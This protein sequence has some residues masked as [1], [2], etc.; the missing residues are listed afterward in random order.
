MTH[1]S[2]F[3]LLLIYQEQLI[4]V[5]ARDGVEDKLVQNILCVIIVLHFVVMKLLNGP[6]RHP[7]FFYVL[8]F[9]NSHILSGMKIQSSDRCFGRFPVRQGRNCVK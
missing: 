5:I 6:R 2:T 1:L 4:S 3:S 7:L 8:T 9:N